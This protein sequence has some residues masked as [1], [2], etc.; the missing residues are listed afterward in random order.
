MIIILN[1]SQSLSLKGPCRKKNN[2]RIRIKH[3]GEGIYRTICP[4]GRQNTS[5]RLITATKCLKT[6]P[7]VHVFNVRVQL[8]SAI[9][10][11]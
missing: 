4:L 3:Q 7:Y 10:H 5:L 1:E 2:T 9:Y 11:R 6:R 8:R